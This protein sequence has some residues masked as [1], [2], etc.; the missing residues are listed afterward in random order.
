MDIDK[1]I[2]EYP[3]MQN[4][5]DG[6]EIF[7]LNER[8]GEKAELPFSIEEMR[9]AEARLARFAPYIQAAFPETAK[10]GGIIESPLTEINK[11]KAFFEERLGSPFPG[12]LFLKC[13]SH[14]AVSGSIKARGGIYEVLK[15]AE[16][17]AIERGMLK[18]TDDYA[19][20]A[21]ERFRNLFA[22]YSV[23]VGSTG[24]LGLSIGI[25]SAKLGFKVTVHMSADARQWKKDL[26][27]YKGVTVVEYQDDYQKAVAEGRREAEKDPTCHFVDDEGSCDLF[28]GYSV[29]A[30]RLAEQFKRQLITCDKENPVFVYIP[31]GVGGAPGGVA[32][33]LKQLFGDNV[34]I[35]FAEPTHAPCMTLGM[36][37][38]LHDGISVGDI[39]LDGKT[40]ADGLAVGRPSRLVG[41][42]METLLDGCF[43]IED[44]KLYPFLTKLADTENLFIEPS[45]CACFTGPE[46]VLTAEGYL[47][48]NGLKDKLKNATHILWATGGNMVPAEEM[49]AYYHMGK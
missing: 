33:G 30:F 31:C 15:L 6:E 22:E 17:I 1:L 26:L 19:V 36:L 9:D 47:I 43:T 45:A 3:V 27:R 21:E 39:G 28:L 44:E 12:R 32:F 13:D 16:Q 34:H 46:R 40:A 37:T 24:N 10:T 14:L 48:K 5:I 23:A 42:V 18:E 35:F 49:Q 11:M 20:L 2:V 8:A 38:G 25:I 29:A 41:S 7:W 4:M